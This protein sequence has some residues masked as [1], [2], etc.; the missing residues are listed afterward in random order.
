MKFNTITI[1]TSKNIAQKL[2]ILAKEKESVRRKLVVTA[3]ELAVT[4]KEKE[5]VR[6]KL[7]VTAKQLAVT[8]REK[9]SVR[10]KLVVT[11]KELAVTAKEKENARRKLEVTAKQLAV[12]AREKESTRRKLVV[13][14]EELKGLY[15]TLEKKVLERTKDLEQIRAKNEAI[16]TSIGDGLVVVDKEG[17]I[18]YINKSFEEMLGWKAEEIIGKSMVEVVPR[19]DL[20][21]IEVDRKSVV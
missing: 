10:Q 11:A 17:K 15:E 16:L 14:A 13:I 8:A 4:A 19:E 6:R 12:T 18:S 1:S 21:G 20:N 5:S 2:E 9:E 3:K 7:V